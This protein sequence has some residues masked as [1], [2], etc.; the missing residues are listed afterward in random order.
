MLNKHAVKQ[1]ITLKK[2]NLEKK[3]VFRII[4]TF[5]KKTIKLVYFW[6]TNCWGVTTSNDVHRLV[7]AKIH[8]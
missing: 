1:S 7:A 2:F 6:K 3:I 8:N 5:Q 4:Y